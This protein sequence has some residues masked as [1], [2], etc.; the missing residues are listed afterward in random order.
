MLVVSP[1]LP[2]P[3]S[4]GGA[5]RIYN[6]CRALE[7]RVDF[8]LACFREKNDTVNYGKLHE[9]FRE[10]YVLDRDE[11]ASRDRP[12]A[13]GPRT[14]LASLRALIADRKPDL[15]QI[16]FTH[17]AHFR[18]AA[19]ETPPSWW[20]TTSPSL[21]TASSPSAIPA[22]A[23]RREYE[24][25]LAF[26]RH[27]LPRYDAVWTMS[28]DDRA[29]ALAEGA[30]RGPHHRGRQWRGYRALRPR[31]RPPR[32]WRVFYVGSFRH[33]PNIIGFEKL[34]HE[35]MPRVWR[36]FPERGCAW[37]PAPSRSDTGGVDAP[38]LSARSRFPHPGSRLCGRS[39][40]AL[41]PAAV[42][43]VPL[44]SR[45]APISK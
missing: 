13:A 29:Q 6:L 23:A 31:C 5:V 26:E 19:P 36:R 15:L 25:W 33:L 3:L 24:R 34:R 41:R 42:V 32:R 30:P 44:A 20:S 14:L 27:W 40:A 38:R 16:E 7:P 37:L 9:V 28:E 39:A 11:K 4:H 45:P 21:S 43:A 1:Y 22:R 17:L 10:V 35:I 8:I 18:D 12:A 2:Y